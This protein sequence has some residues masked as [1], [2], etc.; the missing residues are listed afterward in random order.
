MSH[1]HA[2]GAADGNY[3]LD[4][5][6]TILACG[7][8]GLVAVLMY[9]VPDA[10]G[11]PMLAR[12]LVPMFFKWVVGGGIAIMLMALI[13]AVAIWQLAGQR[14][15]E[16]A[17]DEQCGHDHPHAE[18]CGHDHAHGADHDHA[19]SHSHSHSHS[20]AAEEEEAHEHNW[21][22]WRYMVIA[23]PVFLYFLGLPRPGFSDAAVDR[24]K[25]TGELSNPNR[26]ALS[27]LAGGPALTKALRK[28]EPRELRLGFKELAQ[29]AAMPALHDHYEGDIGI[30][31]GQ[32]SAQGN[33]REFT[34][35]RMKMTCCVADAIMLET[36]VVSPEPLRIP[37]QTWVTVKGVISFEKT[38]KGKWVPVLTLK[39]SD[40]IDTNTDPVPDADSF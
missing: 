27:F 9:Y 5:L 2:H 22:P 31:R 17:A 7:G 14:R 24:Q 35:F 16:L 39:S 13:R 19:H 21:A 12:I 20:N 10:N 15:Q 4:Q 36:R 32:F 1:S 23:I 26:K 11:Q 38:E 29:A 34:L 3:F 30:I 33:D 8:I 37:D 18:E 6:F 25:S 28:G 40:D